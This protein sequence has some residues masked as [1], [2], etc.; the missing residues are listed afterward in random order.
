MSNE[1]QPTLSVY[2][3]LTPTHGPVVVLSIDNARVVMEPTAA[4]MLACA[5]VD[6]VKDIETAKLITLPCGDNVQ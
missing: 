1:K 6:A 2:V 4:L 5:I 3:Q